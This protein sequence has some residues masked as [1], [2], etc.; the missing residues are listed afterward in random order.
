[1]TLSIA[2]IPRRGPRD[3]SAWIRSALIR[4]PL[5]ATLPGEAVTD[6]LERAT[7]RRVTV[8]QL[9]VSQ[10]ESGD[11]MYII[12]RGRVKVVIYGDKGREVI[13]SILR[14]CDSFGEMA[15]FDHRT[16]SAHC[17][18]TEATMLLV[19]NRDDIMSHITA[20]PQTAIK[21]LGQMANRLRHADER[22]A[23]LALCDAHERLIHQLVRLAECEGVVTAEGY[24]V[25]DRPTQQ[26]LANMIGSC[27]ETIS[28][29]F[30]QLARDGLIIPRG[31]HL[32]ITRALLHRCD[33]SHAA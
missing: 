29:L 32:V 15:L 9:I 12:V 22:I 10:G 28:R 1:M 24:L 7:I 14:R 6:L 21:L 18:A 26:E 5:F 30:V 31:R 17:V 20:Y 3:D 25:N 19:L 11:T 27:R 16:R 2:P 23:R 8:N 4:T 33:N 13:L